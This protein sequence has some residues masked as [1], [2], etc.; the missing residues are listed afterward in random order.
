MAAGGFAAELEETSCWFREETLLQIPLIVTP[1]ISTL[2]TRF[3]P[4][5]NG[6]VV[7]VWGFALGPAAGDDDFIGPLAV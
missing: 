6:P 7:R 4:G 2:L 1:R 3:I 5:N